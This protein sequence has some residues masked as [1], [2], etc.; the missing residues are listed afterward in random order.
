MPRITV[1]LKATE[2]DALFL[3]AEREF[4]DPRMQA[5]LII[6]RELERMGFL[7]ADIPTF[8]ESIIAAAEKDEPV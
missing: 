7:P 8:Q 3:W 4:R 2:R 6:R 1:S 5:S